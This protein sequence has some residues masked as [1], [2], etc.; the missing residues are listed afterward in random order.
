MPGETSWDPG[1]MPGGTLVAPFRALFRLVMPGQAWWDLVGPGHT[2]GMPGWTLV[3]LVIQGDSL[4]RP[5]QPW[6]DL[7][8]PGQTWSVL[9]GHFGC[10][11]GLVVPGL[12]CR[13][14]CQLVMPGR[15]WS[16]LVGHLS[17]W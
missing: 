3:G 8:S 5:G 4:V 9:M 12:T 17:G 15:N 6:W 1:E 16:D 10:R 13:T 7:V 14:F 11:S 2:L